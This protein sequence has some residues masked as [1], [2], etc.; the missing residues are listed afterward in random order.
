MAY[1]QKRDL[2]WLMGGIAGSGVPVLPFIALAPGSFIHEVIVVQLTR[3]NLGWQALSISARFPWMT[4]LGVLPG[5]YAAPVVAIGA[6]TVLGMS[7]AVSY[8]VIGERVALDWFILAAAIVVVAGLCVPHQFFANYGYFPGVWLILL[9]GVVVGRSAR[10]VT[11]GRF[12]RIRNVTPLRWAAA[13]T[14]LIA[15]Y[16]GAI[17]Q[18]DYSRQLTATSIAFDPRL[19]S[20]IR[21]GACVVFDGP[22]NVIGADRF[23]AAKP[24]PAT[25]DVYGQWLAADP[26]HPPSDTGPYAPALVRAWATAMRQADYLLLTSC[27]AVAARQGRSARRGECS[28]SRTAPRANALVATPATP[29]RRS[30]PVVRPRS[31]PGR[32]P[33]IPHSSVHSYRRRSPPGICP[34]S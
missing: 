16:L 19:A 24:C 29:R 9:S 1:K 14:L 2:A 11:A 25:V 26:A 3:G 31:V 27:R 5:P 20:S 22:T 8:S 17:E 32:R 30:G 7:A 33:P 4:G 23:A 6:M 28:G 21:P 10:A 13:M 34:S 18:L 15:A 12:G